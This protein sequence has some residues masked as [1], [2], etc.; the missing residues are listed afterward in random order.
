MTTRYCRPTIATK[1]PV[2][3]E[4][5]INQDIQYMAYS[6]QIPRQEVASGNAIWQAGCHQTLN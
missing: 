3:L 4:M 1:L 2:S 6:Y 5:I